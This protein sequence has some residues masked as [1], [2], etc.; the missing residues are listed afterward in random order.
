MKFALPRA[1]AGVALRERGKSALIA[2]QDHLKRGYRE[3]GERLAQGG[4]L[5]DADLVYFFTHEELCHVVDGRSERH[6]DAAARRRQFDDLWSLAFPVISVGPPL[7]IEVCTPP[8]AGDWVGLPVSRGIAEGRAVVATRLEDARRLTAGD[9]LVARITDVGWS[10]WFGV[11]GALVT[12]IGSPLSHGA[13]VAREYGIPAVVGAKGATRIPDGARI[14]VDGGAGTVTLLPEP[15]D[16]NEPPT[17]QREVDPIYS[18]IVFPSRP[19]RP[20]ND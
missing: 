6:E 9:V 3:L 12:E 14:R 11:A 8:P 16:P 20:R 18:G 1:R 5:P 2:F 19:Q 7:P 4:L 17:R 13:V 15:T 10:P